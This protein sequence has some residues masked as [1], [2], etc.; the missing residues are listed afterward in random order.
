MVAPAA[1]AQNL[2]NPNKEGP[3]GVEVNTLTGNLFFTRTDVVLPARGFN[4]IMSF[5]YNSF[6][7][8]TNLGYGNGWGFNYDIR[9]KNDTANSKTIVWGDG[10]EDNYT[11][12]ASGLKGPRGYYTNLAE[13]QAGKYLLTERNGVKYY[14]DN[15]THKKI[16][17]MEDLNG[18]F[19]GFNY[20][21][22]LLTSVSNNSGQIITLNYDASGKLTS[23]A[24]ANTLPERTWTYA[25]DA[26]GNLTSAKDPLGNAVNYAYMVNGPMKSIAD[27]NNNLVDIIYYPDIRISE[28]VGCNKRI[29]FSYDST[30]LTTV[31]TDHLEN[32]KDQVTKYGYASYNN[33]VWLKS[34]TGNCC[35]FNMSFEYDAQGNKIKETDAN[36]NVYT[37]TY[38]EQGNMISVTDPLN[39]TNH[40]TYNTAFNFV[41]SHIDPKGFK[42]EMLYDSKGNLL[43]IKEPGNRSWK[44]TYA[45][46]GDI[47]TSTDPEGNVYSYTYNTYGHPATVAGPNEF[48]ATFGFDAR[49]QLLAY[50]NSRNA[51]M[52]AEYDILSRIKKV[53]DP[54]NQ[55]AGVQY[56]ANGNITETTNANNEKVKVSYDASDRPVNIN[57]AMN[58]TTTLNFN[59]NNYLTS[60]V[61]ALGQQMTLE[62]DGQNRLAR[63]VNPLGESMQFSYDNIGNL[64]NLA[65]PDGRILAYSYDALNRIRQISDNLG[66]LAELNYDANNNIT[67]FKNGT[68]AI[69]TAS[70]DSLNRLRSI[71]DPLGNSNTFTYDAN[72]RVVS[73]TDLKGQT[74]RYTYDGRNRVVS[75][76]DHMG[77]TI[78][79]AY[80]NTSNIKS[81]TDQN[82]NTTH[83]EYDAINR[84]TKLTYADGSYM[85]YAYDTK[86]NITNARLTDG[87]TIQYSYDAL[88]R[89][90]TKTLPDGRTFSYTYDALG[91]V[92]TAGNDAGTVSFT[93]DNL[94][95]LISES[96]N[97]RTVQY[98][99]NTAGRTTS[100]TYPDGSVV[101]RQ[102]DERNRLT[103]VAENGRTLATYTYNS[104]DQVLSRTMANGVSTQ[105]QYDISGKLVGYT[106]GNGR[107][108]QAQITYDQVGNKTSIIRGN[109]PSY[110]VQFTYDAN[111]RLTQY[112]R[113]PVGSHIIQNS[114][115]YDAVGNRL[116]ANSNG[117]VSNYTVN[118]LNQLTQKVT[119]AG[120]TNLLYDNNGNLR[121]DGA[122]YKTYDAE[123]R[124]VKDSASPANVLTYQ[125]DALG[126]RVL[127]NINGTVYRYSFAAYTPIEEI[128][129]GNQKTEQV[130][131]GFLAPI[132]IEKEGK[133]YYY[134][135]NESGSVEAILDSAG[136]M[137][138]RYEYDVYGAQKRFDSLGNPLQGSLVGNRAGF[139]G[140]EY[141]SVTN[142]NDFFYRNYNSELGVFQQR[143]LIGYADGTG[144]YQYVHNNP[145]NGIDIFGLESC[146][147]KTQTTEPPPDKV[148][149]FLAWLN[150]QASNI[151]N[152]TA[153]LKTNS[154]WNAPGLNIWF[155][156]FA[157]KATYDSYQALGNWDNNSYA[158]NTN[159][160]IDLVSNGLNATMGTATATL[161]GGGTFAEM[162]FGGQSFSAAF[163]TATGEAGGLFATGGSITGAGVLVATAGGLAIY[164]F[165]NEGVKLLNGGHSFA[166]VGE[167]IPNPV[168]EWLF[169]GDKY[170]FDNIPIEQF[171]RSESGMSTELNKKWMTIRQQ[172]EDGTYHKRRR[173]IYNVKPNC[174]Q[175]GDNGGTNRKPKYWY[176]PVTGKLEI[177]S[178]W[179]PNEIIGPAGQPTKRW[180]SVNDRLPYTVT[181]E[182]DKSATAPA[183]LV[184]VSVPIDTKMDA[185]TFELGGFGFNS[186]T[187]SI[188]PGNASYYQRLD[189]RDSLGLYV[190]FTA[191][192]DVTKNE[193]FW[194]LQSIDPV[195]LQPPA[196]PLKG[197]LLRQ[198]S[199]NPQYGHGFV[200][201]SI[202][203]VANAVTLDTVLASA[204]IIFD[205]NEM[206]PTNVEKNTIDA[207][208]P[209]SLLTTLPGTSPVAIPL[210]W[211]GRDDT[212]GCGIRY[213]TLYVSEDGVNFSILRS[214]ITRTDTVI[215]GK[216][217]AQLCFFVLATDSVGNTEKLRPEATRCTMVS[218]T[219]P[220]SWL[221]FT[222]ANQGNDNLL[223]WATASEQNTAYFEVERSP[224]GS[225]FKQIGK[226][227]AAGSSSITS[228]YQYTD[229]NV[230]KL[231]SHV[232]YYRLRQVDRDGKAT[233]SNVV[234]MVLRD[235]PATRS[236]V[237]PNPTAR[238]V[239]I[240]TGTQKLIGTEAIITDLSGKVLGRFKLTT[241][242]Q[243]V[244]MDKLPGGIYFIRLASKEV[245]KVVKQ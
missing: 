101:V 154:I 119:G 206:I 11:I 100:V 38:D 84:L 240:A 232:Q 83:Y 169:S 70:Y 236:L 14:F 223:R 212:N 185:A 162:A 42:T 31:V 203:P 186:L 222:G 237:Y 12:A 67:S 55:M 166:E 158:Q 217:G 30:A 40:Y 155:A 192:Y 132:S 1:M 225:R 77:A 150:S 27:R 164:G 243:E 47:L 43:E 104:N 41:S 73:I 117:I 199:L 110:S 63:M 48:S 235:V 95:R 195:T 144:L 26:S 143:D 92:L 57:D 197:L 216:P 81:L 109:N 85:T 52:T 3:M 145:A 4:M 156:P 97:G 59:A 218:A 207:F 65:L 5:H 116:T 111:Y 35:G 200:N 102:H 93:Y 178:S 50:T 173:T 2:N 21:D 181:F 46:N 184:R 233:Y 91:R 17:R 74:N 76:T 163:A 182:N 88:N 106:S 133:K 39:Q 187:F 10:R 159:S 241:P 227:A 89:M 113:G 190:D 103:S 19:L 24:D 146:T 230:H 128:V 112:K 6:N 171:E 135:P 53:T 137:M 79:L 86:N 60:F 28:I 15:N 34:I 32:G 179:D 165:A 121:F 153:L 141:D 142:G 71:T 226:V 210:S 61:N 96:F 69:V 72:N 49:G 120:T 9:Y 75:M 238:N 201:F 134:L 194:L 191:G 16:T 126:R 115:T 214:G 51:Q 198:D 245:L 127:K 122:F 129:G 157:I 125:Y 209:T 138:E 183:K 90:T 29:S 242:T 54:L 33:I 20:R 188:P 123:R 231:G 234:R 175:N 224:D 147:N 124:L 94:N 22:T 160:V 82:G 105:F 167:M 208:A 8:E 139:T 170:G 204:E 149:A 118:N 219:L 211:S 180:V 205:S 151:P 196:D 44:A 189:C 193:A 140:Q 23:I 161:I 202:K 152:V 87:T 25:Y 36:G 177:I 131:S 114:Y 7:F 148:N 220:V 62:Y 80:D 18:N 56:D 98:S 99:Y 221:Y 108:Q 78:Q 213:Y 13:Y 37:M 136:R 176:N 239:Y 107:W 68:G 228:T 45:A 215:N 244:N 58:N 64:T 229:Y 130:Y 66:Q 172:I 174:P 168:I